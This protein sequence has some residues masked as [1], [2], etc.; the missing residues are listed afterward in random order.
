MDLRLGYE[1]LDG[2][3]GW[4]LVWMGAGA[5]DRLLCGSLMKWHSPYL[6]IISC[7]LLIVVM[8][9]YCH[10]DDICSAAGDSLYSS[11]IEFTSDSDPD[12]HLVLE[13]TARLI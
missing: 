13:A 3:L 6:A 2:P 11:D 7:L 10:R 1:L 5:A 12:F 4:L 9:R 8:Y